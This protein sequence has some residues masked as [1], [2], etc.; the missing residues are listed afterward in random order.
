MNKPQIDRQ[1]IEDVFPLSAIQQGMAY[2]SA[3]HPERSVYHNQVILQLKDRRFAPDLL[4]WALRLLSQRHGMLRTGFLKNKQGRWMQVVRRDV[5]PRYR[6]LDLSPL[7]EPEQEEEIRRFLERDKGQPFDL[8]SG[9]ILWRAQS[10]D[11]G[12]GEICLVWICHHAMIDGWSGAT[13]AT[14]INDTYLRLKE[15]PAL[16]LPVMR[17]SYKLYVAEQ[18]AQRE[19]PAAL[20]FWRR[21]LEGYRRFAFP[22]P[23]TE[24][25]AAARRRR[26]GK[27]L[28]QEL[29]EGLRLR[30]KEFGLSLK[31]LCFTAYMGALSMFSFD[32]DVCAGLVT[33]NRPVC[34]DAERMIGCFLNTVPARLK[35]PWGQDWLTAARQ[36]DQLLRRVKAYDMIPLFDIAQAMGETGRDGNPICDVIFNFVD[37]FVYN[38]ARQGLMGVS[39]R[40][41]AVRGAGDSNTW[42]DVTVESTGRR[43][44]LVL[45]FAPQFV[46][47][48]TVEAFGDYFQKI[49]TAFGER[50]REQARKE[51]L[52][53]PDEKRM[54]L[55]TF[56]QTATPFPA[57]ASIPKLLKEQVELH[58]NRIALCHCD[59]AVS[60]GELWRRATAL[61][62]ELQAGGLRPNGIVALLADRSLETIIGIMGILCAG[63]A[64]L[65]LDPKLPSQRKRYMI[66]DCA[67]ALALSHEPYLGELEGEVEC[68]DLSSRGAAVQPVEVADPLAY[69]IYTSGTTGKPKGAV[70]EHRAVIRL[71]KEAN[72]ITVSPSDRMLQ[73]A[74]VA[75][76]GSVFDIF[77]ALLNGACLVLA[78]GGSVMS[79]AEL[80][81]LIVSEAVTLFFITTALFNAL[82]DWDPHCLSGVRH[83]L[84]GG[85]KASRPHCDRGFETLGP[86]RLI[87]LYGPTE[88]TVIT[89]AYRLRDLPPDGQALP[90]GGP[91]SNTTVFV[92]DSLRQPVPI[93]APGE[94]YIGGPGL[95]RGY[96]NRPQLTAERFVVVDWV[97]GERLYRSGDLVRWL[98][99]GVLDYL[100]RIDT[101]VKIR[102]FRVETAEIQWALCQL[103]E[104]LEAVVEPFDGHGGTVGLCAYITGPN[105]AIPVEEI[106]RKLAAQLQDFMIP[107]RVMWLDS[108]PL[109]SNGKVDRSALPRLEPDEPLEIVPPRDQL[110]RS[111]LE[112]WAAVLGQE[113]DGISIHRD[114]FDL[115]GHSL[116]ATQLV[117]RLQRDM[118]AAISLT[119]LFQ[120]P[121]VAGLAELI[122][123]GRPTQAQHLPAAEKRDYYPLSGAQKRLHLLH[124]LQPEATVYNIPTVIRFEDGIEPQTLERALG[125]LVQRHH[126]LRAWF[127]L[128]QDEPVQRIAERIDVS[129]PVTDVDR[130]NFPYGEIFLNQISPFDLAAPPLWRVHLYR[131]TGGACYLFWDIHHIITDGVSQGILKR[132]LF[133]WLQGREVSV[134]KRRYVDFALWQAQT[135]QTEESLALRDFW[136]KSFDPLPLPLDLP[137]DFSRP[138]VQEYQGASVSFTLHREEENSLRWMAREGDCTVFMVVM[139]VFQTLLAKLS[140]QEDIVVGVPVAGRRAADVEGIVGMFVNTLP[141]RFRP[142]M[143][144]SWKDFLA[145]VRQGALQAFDHQDLQFEELVELLDIERD[146]GRGPLFDVMLNVLD[147]EAHGAADHGKPGIHRRG[148]AKFDLSLF[149]VDDGRRLDLG[150]EYSTRMFTSRT[151]DAMTGYFRNLVRQVGANPGIGLRQLELMGPEERDMVLRQFNRTEVELPER[152]SMARQLNLQALAHPD[153]VALWFEDI[154]LS[155]ET[156]NRRVA[157]LALSL[158]HRGVGADSIVAVHMERSAHLVTAILAVIAAGGAYL[159]LSE[160]NPPERTRIILRDSGASLLLQTGTGEKKGDGPLV[161]DVTDPRLYDGSIPAS[162]PIEHGPHD[163]FYVLYTSGSTGTPKGV[164]VENRGVV[165]M[166]RYLERNFP[167]GERGIFIFKTNCMFDVSVSELFGW[168]LG[169]GG[170]AILPQGHEKDPGLIARAVGLHQVTHIDFV[171]S[172]LTIFLQYLEPAERAMLGSLKYVLV[173]GEEFSRDLADTVLRSRL[174]VTVANLCGP[175]ET[176]IYATTYI[177]PRHCEAGPVPIGVPV[178]NVTHYIVEPDSGN[179]LTPPL[180]VGEMLIGGV[181][182]GRGYLNRPDLTHRRFGRDPFIQGGRMYRS[183]DLCRW[184]WNG[185]ADYLGR[186]DHQV[187]I[188]GNRVELGEI[189]NR[190]A[191]HPFVKAAVVTVVEEGGADPAIAAYIIPAAAEIPGPEEVRE[192][193]ASMLPAYMVPTYVTVLESFPRNSSGKIARRLLPPPDMTA[194][195]VAIPTD[196]LELEIRRLFAAVLDV[197]PER[198]GRDSDFFALGGHSLKANVLVARLKRELGLK[199]AL[200]DVFSHLSVRRLAAV[201]HRSASTDILLVHDGTGGLE[202]YGELCKLLDPKLVCR[203]V[204]APHPGEFEGEGVDI[205]TLARNYL[206][207]AAPLSSG[208]VIVGWSLGAT[209]GFEMALQLEERGLRA[210]ALVLIDGLP[211]L[212]AKQR[213]DTTPDVPA[214]QP[215]LLKRFPIFRQP[216]YADASMEELSGLALRLRALNRAREDYLPTGRLDTPVVCVC[217]S[218]STFVEHQLWSRHIKG[219]LQYLTID[220]DHFSLLRPPAARELA[221]VLERCKE[222]RK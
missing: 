6:H 114:F 76:D 166:M 54:L 136:R 124:H 93:G 100:G 148:I 41:L 122:R 140:L 195:E 201:A 95:A 138:P 83:V 55:E 99:D 104:V 178:D 59:Q 149:V 119:D 113:A 1:A 132:D 211:P 125:F 10:F 197:P 31:S 133:A 98:P 66:R 36:A 2:L 43:F 37:F 50:P 162:A 127:P 180:M 19:N 217:A 81:N 45:A 141:L 96:L 183:G 152:L 131:L 16:T 187:K 156:L 110:E 184:R 182:V 94:L 219:S 32:N 5:Q 91:V 216:A 200:L 192:F 26:A 193:T 142:R 146:T 11:V 118:E 77:G 42:L 30:A 12:D 218:G 86:G 150:F 194:E 177:L 71:V 47:P 48:E 52:L 97:G 185:V 173:A 20:E 220:G 35:F 160:D 23:A 165:N 208:T 107:A 85:E 75:F 196:P 29:G 89:S 153:R 103:P 158:R 169:A 210:G 92:L 198:V 172:M 199:V 190:L 44:E 139:A 84:F 134:P 168:I 213:R 111:I 121:T 204:S 101:Q 209:V 18:L 80:G 159:A 68:V 212:Q 27:Q 88:A 39:S 21:E 116:K 69:V 175:T 164:L 117:A 128:L 126:G 123:G 157:Q 53:A 17:S 143:D 191:Q 51:D 28:G 109:N 79:L 207:Q 38:Q 154:Q 137:A 33:N 147:R 61:A 112:N 129:L 72:Y 60:Y 90:I 171:P 222:E 179:R 4:E 161:M 7:T 155:Y 3:Q 106:K 57:E 8:T 64:Y 130:D 22:S 105:R 56:N 176:T 108:I 135:T 49:L 58:P 78:P 215:T 70:V 25:D 206:K 120:R 145:E 214:D 189:E 188:R 74:N 174:D 181:G 87:N 13:L 163:L 170:V 202:G 82:L 46:A 203:G 73:L 144:T 14:E 221:A 205:E 115:G 102:G 65:P 34:A 15:D 62:G 151:I 9:E 186:I 24:V 67:V 63:G 167:M 40:R